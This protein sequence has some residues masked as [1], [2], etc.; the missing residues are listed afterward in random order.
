[1]RERWQD[2]HREIRKKCSYPG[3]TLVLVTETNYLW[4]ERWG[5][6]PGDIRQGKEAGANDPVNHAYVKKAQLN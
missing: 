4:L 5:F 3:K 6:G 1:M 2:G